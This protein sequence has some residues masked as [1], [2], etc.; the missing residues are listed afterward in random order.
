MKVLDFFFLIGIAF[1]LIF[2]YHANSAGKA[3]LGSA[4]TLCATAFAVIYG[5]R[6][7]GRI[8]KQNSK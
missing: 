8:R 3:E 4:L 6:I 7:G 2:A 5:V 1:F